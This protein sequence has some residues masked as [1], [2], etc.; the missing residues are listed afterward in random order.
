MKRFPAPA[1]LIALALPL[2]AG[3][4]A[5]SNNEANQAEAYSRCS[6]TPGPKERAAC[7]KTELALIEARERR[8]AEKVQTDREA[9][10]RRQAEL[11]AS[12]LSS[13]DARQT[14]DSGLSLPH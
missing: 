14:V 11:E 5:A 4:V 2:M 13:E 7:I 10:E 9:A 1:L 12:G 3:C 8:D 6:Y